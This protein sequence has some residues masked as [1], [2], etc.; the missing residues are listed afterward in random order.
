MSYF[1]IPGVG[2]LK[3]LITIDFYRL[4]EFYR[5]SI[6]ILIYRSLSIFTDFLKICN[7]LE[8]SNIFGENGGKIFG[9]CDHFLGEGVLR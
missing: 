1:S 9:G 2:L 7:F 8:K 6:R 4:A 3:K 5:L